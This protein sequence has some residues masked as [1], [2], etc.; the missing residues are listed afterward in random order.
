MPRRV[1]AGQCL[2]VEAP[3]LAWECPESCYCLSMADTRILDSMADS[4]GT[5]ART[6][7]T[8]DM[9]ARTPA[10]NSLEPRLQVPS[11]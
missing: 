10:T 7:H 3:G 5:L 6:M 4:R 11:R 1:G 8:R 9:M 2:W